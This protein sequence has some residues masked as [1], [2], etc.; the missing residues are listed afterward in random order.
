MSIDLRK[1]I[2][3]PRVRFVHSRYLKRAIYVPMYN[4]ITNK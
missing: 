3:T 1:Q 2:V 4:T